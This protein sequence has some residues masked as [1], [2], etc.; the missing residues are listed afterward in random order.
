MYPSSVY[1]RL[2]VMD[3]ENDS[4]NCKICIH[5]SARLAVTGSAKDC[6]RILLLGMTISGMN[7]CDSLPI[8]HQQLKYQQFKSLG[9]EIHDIHGEILKLLRDNHRTLIRLLI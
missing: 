2:F 1:D 8:H 4:P 6:G 5:K 9:P 3:T 7:T